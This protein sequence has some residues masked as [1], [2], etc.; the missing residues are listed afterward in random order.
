[1]SSE[2]DK[3]EAAFLLLVIALLLVM[4]GFL[5]GLIRIARGLP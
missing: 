2:R 5:A 4:L 3:E 1:M